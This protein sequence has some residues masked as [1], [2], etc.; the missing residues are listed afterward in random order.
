MASPHLIAH[1]ERLLAVVGPSGAGKDSVLKAWRALLLPPRPA[2][3]ARLHHAQ[4]VI[5]RAAD[6]HGE[7]HEPI[8]ETGFLA[9]RAAGAL[10]VQWQAHG[11]HYGVRHQ[12]LAPLQAGSW[13][14]LNAS[15][16]HLPRLRAAAPAVRVVEI[17]APPAMLAQRLAARSRED[18]FAVEAR[19]ARYALP[20]QAELVVH[21]TG[22]VETA[23]L[24]LHA[25]WERLA[26]G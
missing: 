6:P 19:L 20:A 7:A 25:W 3:A 14:V 2:L 21:N 12:A 5:T 15:R 26:A 24:Q 9:L 8:D 11:L 23:A 4:R 18:A 22:D 10:A 1:S 17:T 13:V 16:E